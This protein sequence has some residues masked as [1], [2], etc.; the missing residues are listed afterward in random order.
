M[1]KAASVRDHASI[2]DDS[3]FLGRQ[4]VDRFD[5]SLAA[6]EHDGIPARELV[7]QVL[8]VQLIA[9]LQAIISVVMREKEGENAVIDE[10]LTVNARETLS[11]HD[12]QA[13]IARRRGGVFA[14]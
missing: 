11:D 13:E 4:M 7:A 1:A 14:R 9:D 8:A 3:D 12:A 5:V 10:I 2:D 6:R